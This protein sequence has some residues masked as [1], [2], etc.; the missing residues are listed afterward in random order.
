MNHYQERGVLLMGGT[1]SE[2]GRILV[3]DNNQPI[4]GD[5]GLPLGIHD[6]TITEEERYKG[7]KVSSL[8]P[9]SEIEEKYGGIQLLD[10]MPR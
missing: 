4:T 6:T 1:V 5:N 2:H 10:A 3:D 7:K 9:L 8:M